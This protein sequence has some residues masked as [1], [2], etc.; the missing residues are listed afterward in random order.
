MSKQNKTSLLKKTLKELTADEVKQ[1]EKPLGTHMRPFPMWGTL[2]ID[3]EGHQSL[4]QHL[5]VIADDAHP[6]MVLSERPYEEVIGLAYREMP[7]PSMLP[8]F[9]DGMERRRPDNKGKLQFVKGDPGAGKSFMGALLGRMRTKEPVEV[10]DCGGKNMREILFETVLDFGANE[11]LPKAIDTHIEKGTIHALSLGLLEGLPSNCW[12][13]DSDGKIVIDW[14]GLKDSGA[15]NVE[16]AFEVL[17]KVSKIEGLDNAGGNAL[18]MN[19]QFGPAIISFIEGR[20]L[21]LDEYNKSKEGT[22]D[23]LQTFL[24]FATGEIDECMVENPLKNKDTA[25]GP[26]HFTF[27]REDMKTG[28][29]LTLTGNATEDGMTTRKLNKSVSSRLDPQVLPEPTVMDWQHRTCQIMV[30]L[31]VS[32]LYRVF[33]EEADKNPDQFAEML[34][35]W[36]KAGLNED[37]VANIPQIELDLLQDWQKVV[38][39]TEKMAKF[40][41]G[42]KE[43]VDPEIGPM[44]FPDLIEEVDEDFSDE[45]SIDFR[46]IIKHLEEAMPI[47]PKMMPL[48]MGHQFEAAAW[49][50]VPERIVR[51]DE[52][53]KLHFGTRLTDLLVRKVYE[54][55]GAINK[56]AL[57]QRL[58]NLMEQSGLKEL[59]LQEASK[60]QQRSV[61]ELLNISPFDT[62]DPAQQVK[63]AQKMFC[64]Y[65]REVDENIKVEDNE[66][67]ITTTQLRAA[68]DNLKAQDNSKVNEFFVPNMD[69][70]TLEQ[71]PF[72]K[73]KMMDWQDKGVDEKVLEA[74]K[75]DDLVSQDDLL[76]SFA[77]PTV[78]QKNVDALWEE[79]ISS[80]INAGMADSSDD[81]ALNGGGSMDP[82]DMVFSSDMDMIDEAQ[83][84]AENSS[85]T[86][87]AA[88]TVVVK[89]IENGEAKEVSVHIVSNTNKNKMVIVSGS[90]SPRMEALFKEAGITHINRDE[91]NAEKR[92]D[93]AMTELLR[94][95]PDVEEVKKHIKGAFLYRNGGEENHEKEALSKLMVTPE[96]MSNIPKFIVAP[97]KPKAA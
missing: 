11:A 79:N 50:D 82:D 84:I 37:Q 25:A 57:Y 47:K 94:G 10:L 85:E 41:H 68:L 83:K 26:S 34:M 6:M 58:Q 3:H 56:P 78:G 12:E 35:F 45:I 49:K 76:S 69:H 17:K 4:E 91:P 72:V 46:K 52:D 54:T 62:K 81:D 92:V 53:L 18:G 39:A 71:E 21:V 20:E 42:W 67:I 9:F 5:T 24:Q 48:D 31:P 29:F 2:A 86:G 7:V 77:M 75:P 60:S 66:Q 33:K 22:D 8:V 19:S 43:L 15:E 16:A 32:T 80:S 65:L 64:D 27:R 51:P 90:V 55:S 95:T 30:G 73:A 59:H 97:G 14:E 74:I 89:Q 28:W 36:R 44:K 13:K 70:A 93:T 38:Q 96:V 23:N 40:Y 63:L 88:T 61:E 1:L 87:I